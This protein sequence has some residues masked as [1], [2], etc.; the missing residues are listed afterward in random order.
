MQKCLALTAILVFHAFFS[1]A[2]DLEKQDNKKVTGIEK[3]SRDYFMFQLTY[4]NW[5]N[6]PD[7]VKVGGFGRGIN[8]YICYDWPIG[9]SNF[10]FAAGIGIGTSN[11]YFNNQEI[12]LTDTGSLGDQVRFIPETK[13]YKR[14]KLTTAYLEAP[15]ELRYFGNKQNRNKG[16]KAALGFRAGTIVGAH[17]KGRTSV[18]GSK[19]SEKTNT[20]RYLETWRFAGTLRLGWGNFSLFGSYNINNLFKS[21]AGP[22]VTPYSIGICVSGL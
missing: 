11:I 20:R 2:Q 4:E 9:K 17:A 15:F 19:V 8:A 10:S 16:F 13:D 7:S 6:R 21:G 14:Y 1:Q 22:E 3:A 12:A 18:D 5:N